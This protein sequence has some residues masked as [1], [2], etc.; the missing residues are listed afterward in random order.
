MGASFSCNCLAFADSV[1]CWLGH[2]WD[3]TLHPLFHYGVIPA[4]FAAGLAYTGELTMDPV[5]LFQKVVIN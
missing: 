2:E 1:Y 3:R 5:A 4:L